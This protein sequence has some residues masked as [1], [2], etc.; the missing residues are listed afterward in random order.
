MNDEQL[1]KRLKVLTPPDMPAALPGRIRLA[2]SLTPQK[3]RQEFMIALRQGA[4]IIAV[5]AD[6]VMIAIRDDM[7]ARTIAVLLTLAL[8]F[9]A[10][11]T[12]S[13]LNHEAALA[14]LQTDEIVS[15]T[16]PVLGGG[17]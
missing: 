16:D 10:W 1:I 2:A 15:E 12:A 4:L 13:S 9:G 11:Q 17:L 5:A 7:R 8:A 14:Q 6:G 3:H